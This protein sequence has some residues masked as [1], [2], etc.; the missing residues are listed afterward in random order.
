MKYIYI[1]FLLSL[2][3]TG[4]QEQE[5]ENADID[6]ISIEKAKREDLSFLDKIEVIP[7]KTDS[8]SLIKSIK[9]MQYVKELNEYIILDSRQVLFRFD[10]KG[11]FISSS[12]NR[13]GEGPENYLMAIDV[14]YNPY[15]QCFEL[16][17]PSGEGLVNAYDSSFSKVCQF[18]LSQSQET[19]D[20]MTILNDSIY[21]FTPLFYKDE[22]EKYVCIYRKKNAEFTMSKLFYKNSIANIHM[23]TLP[24]FLGDGVNYFTPPCFDYHFYRIDMKNN[25]LIPAIKLDFGLNTVSKQ[26]L[27]ERFGQASGKSEKK[28]VVERN[29]KIIM[30]KN[31]YLLESE[32]P[33][34]IVRLLSED[35]IYAFIITKD[36]YYNFIYNRK[37]KQGYLI[38]D[39]FFK[40][41]FGS[42]LEGDI[43]YTYVDACDI[44]EYIDSRY[45]SEKNM[46]L[47]ENIKEDDNQLI[48]KYY[49]RK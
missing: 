46:K 37:E 30:D 49:L 9:R 17:D 33:L 12:S 7:L 5:R 24:C 1:L 25:K 43:I 11:N 32:Y 22:G 21:L 27:D 39:S 45:I 13:R 26:K 48:I 15:S 40:M 3:V 44:N 35:F 18:C 16:Y 36:Q 47:I 42:F 41:P 4:C 8:N 19:Y 14:K 23:V 29:H 10:S 31:S 6:I 2:F 28:N 34:P 20:T 38:S